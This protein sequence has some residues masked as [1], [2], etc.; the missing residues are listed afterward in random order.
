[1][2]VKFICVFVCVIMA[3]LQPKGWAL[4]PG[5]RYTVSAVLGDNSQSNKT[6]TVRGGYCHEE[7]HQF[8]CFQF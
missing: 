7:K 4:L 8:G 5:W 2:C 1:M 3:T 6:A